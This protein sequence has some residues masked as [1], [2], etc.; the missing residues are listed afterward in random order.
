MNKK[1]LQFVMIVAIVMMLPLLVVAAEKKS[2]DEERL[3]PVNSVSEDKTVMNPTTLSE[4]EKEELMELGLRSV[5][6]GEDIN[7]SVI[8]GGGGQSGTSTNYTVSGTVGQVAAGSGTSTNYGVDHGYWQNFISGS[9]VT[10]G[11]ANH[12][13][14]CNMGDAVYIVN[15]AFREGDPP[16]SMNEGDANVDCI[17]HLSD[18]IYIINY[19]FREGP[20]PQCGC[21][22]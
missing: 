12:D 9:C 7:W 5:M 8:G 13:G 16:Q 14:G 19:I 15:Y 20:P 11:D 17:V 6:A 4:A 18:A 21:Y 1:F 22:E 2:A 10:P 3:I